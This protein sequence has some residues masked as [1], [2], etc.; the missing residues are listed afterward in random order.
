MANVVERLPVVGGHR[1]RHGERP[2][3]LPRLGVPH[4]P[5]QRRLAFT[6]THYFRLTAKPQ[7]K[8]HALKA[9]PGRTSAEMLETVVRYGRAIRAGR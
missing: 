1:H 7:P 8:P 3:R 5:R 6:R 4:L 2:G 9:F